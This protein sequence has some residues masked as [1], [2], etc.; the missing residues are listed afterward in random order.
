MSTPTAAP[1]IARARLR[2]G[3]VACA[4]GVGRLLAQ[5]IGTARAVGAG[6]VLARADSA[7][8]GWAFVGTA[9]RQHA[10][11][12]VTVRMNPQVIAAIAGIPDQ[13]WTPI[14]YTD[15]VWDD[16][17]RRWISQAEVAEVPFVAFTSRRKSEHVTCRLVVRRVKRQQPKTGDGTVQGEL[18]AAYRHHGFITNSTLDTVTADERHRDHAIVEQVIAELKDGPLAHLP[19]GHYPANAAW[20]ACAAIAFNLA[21]AAAVAAGQPTARWAT[22]RTRIIGVPAR[23]ASTGRRLVLHLPRGWPWAAQWTQLH[24][25]ATA[26]GPPPLTTT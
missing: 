12:S 8:Y 23:I 6:Q 17:E 19:S 18:F 7:Y 16:H 5:A 24:D 21:R 26:T 20:V 4:A 10:W 11:F 14:R 1:L 2:R 22:L 25:L 3:N 13:A 9:I 15:A